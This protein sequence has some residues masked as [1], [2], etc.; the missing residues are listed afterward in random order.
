MEF[1]FSG[2]NTTFTDFEVMTMQCGTGGTFTG[3]FNTDSPFPVATQNESSGCT[4][5]GSLAPSLPGGNVTKFTI[6]TSNNSS[7]A[8]IQV[9]A[10]KVNGV[11]IDFGQNW[12]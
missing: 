1:N 4:P 2:P 7:N 10:I 11:V 8:S 5:S 9:A 6:T 3:H 12:I